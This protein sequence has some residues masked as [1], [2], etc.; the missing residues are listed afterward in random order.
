[1]QKN[2][3]K[4]SH[5]NVLVAP[6]TRKSKKVLDALAL[7][8]NTL[9]ALSDVLAKIHMG[10]YELMDPVKKKADQLIEQAKKMLKILEKKL[11]KPKMNRSR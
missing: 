3:G 10:I 1:M 6:H 11:N 5:A 9:A 7:E 8:K 4:C 2:E